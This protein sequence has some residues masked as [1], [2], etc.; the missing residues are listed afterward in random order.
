MSLDDFHEFPFCSFGEKAGGQDRGPRRLG[1]RAIV[2]ASR[3]CWSCVAGSGVCVR[4]GL[5]GPRRCLELRRCPGLPRCPW[6]RRCPGPRRCLE[7][8]R[9][10]WPH[11]CPG[12]RR[13]LQ[14]RRCLELRRCPGPR[15]C[16]GPRRC[17]WPRRIPEPRGCPG[18]HRCLEQRRC[19]RP[20]RCPGPR[21]CPRGRAGVPGRA[22]ALGPFA[23]RRPPLGP[24]T[25]DTAAFAPNPCPQARV[26]GQNVPGEST[27][28]K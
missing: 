12:P 26:L 7:Q 28:F 27:S 9:C 10:P 5:G 25:S 18:P 13:C 20:R 21:R 2:H 3:K 1:S 4:L 11:R 22:G 14:L 8:R 15:R 24:A 16:S 23:A 19:P 17:P 6:P